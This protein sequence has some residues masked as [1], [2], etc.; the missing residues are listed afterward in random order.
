ML[1]EYVTADRELQSAFDS[2]VVDAS[3]I[4]HIR[5]DDTWLDLIAR[6]GEVFVEAAIQKAHDALQE[7]D[8]HDAVMALFHGTSQLDRLAAGLTH[9]EVV[10][11]GAVR[12]H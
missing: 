2:L 11:D 7:G 6:Q 5:E 10:Q 3:R 4:A 12:Y 1:D 8:F 9:S